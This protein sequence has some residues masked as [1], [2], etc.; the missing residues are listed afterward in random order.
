MD[1][2]DLYTKIENYLSGNLSEV[3]RFAF[4]DEIQADTNLQAEVTNHKIANRLLYE[5]KLLK[6]K[7]LSSN[8]HET[9]V[10]RLQKRD[11]LIK[12]IAIASLFLATLVM[13]YKWYNSNKTALQPQSVSIEK[14]SAKEGTPFVA[15]NASQKGK[16]IVKKQLLHSKLPAIIDKV[17]EQK[18]LTVDPIVQKS[19][20]II[21]QI[22]KVSKVDQVQP[23]V[24]EKT[25]ENKGSCED[26]DLQFSTNTYST[27]AGASEGLVTISPIEG[28]QK[29]Y[30]FS[31]VDKD[32]NKTTLMNNLPKGAY[33]L[34]VE[35]ANKCFKR[36][37][38]NITENNCAVHYVIQLSSSKYFV[39]A[40]SE[41]VGLFTVRDKANQIYYT[42][43]IPAYN[44]YLWE[45]KDF[46]G[47][48]KEGVYLY[49]IEYK[50]KILNG[51]I[52]IIE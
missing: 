43:T 48:A 14:H 27:C 6:V 45:G 13:V 4:E 10:K 26:V 9:S 20:P 49:T 8:I 29:P 25:K 18:P 1:N 22:E 34:L 24:V 19:T 37:S 41:Q 50:D 3:E 31:I 51:T 33:T 44:D 40:A 2:K 52:T 36:L 21:S 30:T 17:Q 12:T 46:N 15:P 38:I 7:E 32:G 23:K 5:N 47:L 35:D 28:G 42:A 39:Q 16:K 11:F